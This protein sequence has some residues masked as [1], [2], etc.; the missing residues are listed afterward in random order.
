LKSGLRRTLGS[1]RVRNYRLYFAGQ[2]V[3]VS[4]NWMQQIAIAWLIY[5]LT[6]SPFQLG[7]V[8]ALQAMPYLLVGAWG[9]L[10][11]DRLPKRRVLI[12]TQAAQILPPTALWLAVQ[13][14]AVRMWIVYGLVF[15][16]GLVNVVD[17]PARQSFVMEMVGRELVVSAVAL[18]ASVIQAGRLLGPAVAALVIATLG[19]GACFAV[20]ALTFAFMIL[21][22]S[23]MDPRALQPGPRSVGGRGQ[24]RDGVA[25]A[26]ATPGL[27]RPL[28]LTA[29]V[30]LLSFNF[31][32]VLPAIARFT[33]HGTASTYAE[34][35]GFLAVGALVGALATGTRAT[36]TERS[37][38]WASLLFG[39][40]L[41]LAA[42][43]PN[44]DIALAALVGVGAASVA[45]SA[46]V[47]AA[48]QLT[49]APEMRGRVLSLYQILYAGTTPLGALIMG[50]LAS[51]IA[52][53][54]G[55]VVGS[56]AALAA[57]A[58]AVCVK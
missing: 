1:L 5:E 7:M 39:L 9:G 56:V 58:Y 42:A 19:I 15:L 53:Q 11:A 34:M 40:A 51:A 17:N 36:V 33:F 35:M 54:S 23:A 6:N 12:W 14:G 26:L 41:A 49:A 28:L 37:V 47:Q 10:I 32:V 18:N 24:V 57:G 29:V 8:T 3:S 30:G 50:A 31:T 55:L 44:L 52:P 48:L 46:S 38:A 13:T 43:A 2:V 21:M 27:R 20:N 45:F 4:G 25:V 16:R 22:L